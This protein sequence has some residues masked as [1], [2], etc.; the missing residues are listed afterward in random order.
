MPN[1]FICEVFT[2]MRSCHRTR[3][4]SYLT[5]LIEEAQSLANRMEAGL[6]DSRDFE[7][8]REQVSKLKKEKKELEKAVALLKDL[9]GSEDE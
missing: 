7:Y 3:N 1:R 8:L 2:E 5:G 4:Y 9:K 6:S